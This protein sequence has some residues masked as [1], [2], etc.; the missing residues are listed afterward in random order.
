[1]A[2]SVDPKEIE[3]IDEGVG[4]EDVEPSLLGGVGR[5]RRGEDDLGPAQGKGTASFRKKIAPAELYADPSAGRFEDGEA[6]V[7]RCKVEFL[8]PFGEI[9]EMV[10]PVDAGERSIGVENGGGRIVS[11]L[12]LLI[13]RTDENDLIFVCR[14]AETGQ[15]LVVRCDG[16]GTG[17]FLFLVK[18]PGEIEELGETDDACAA[19]CGMG[20][21]LQGLL[22]VRLDVPRRGELDACN[23]DFDSPCR[24]LPSAASFVFLPAAAGTGGIPADFFSFDDG[25]HLGG[26]APSVTVAEDHLLLP[27]ASC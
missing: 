16:M 2:D 24:R 8:P 5:R 25:L 7:A 18:K 1:V 23:F 19:F 6:G 26:P 9:G 10:L 22:Q 12:G 17:L 13:E 27:L 11:F 14:F 15:D 3:V 4:R 20:G 21:E